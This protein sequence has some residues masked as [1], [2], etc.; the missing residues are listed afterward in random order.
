MPAPIKK[1]VVCDVCD[2]LYRSNTTF[3]FLKF[4]FQ[5]E[6]ILKHLALQIMTSKWSLVYYI[7]IVGSKILEKDMIRSL[8]VRLL[9]GYSYSRILSL[10]GEFFDH[11]LNERKN[12]KIFELLIQEKK[13]NYVILVSSSID[14]VI[15]TIANQHGFSYLS[16]VLEVK[17]GKITGRFRSD[18]THKK[19]EE[20]KELM[21]KSP[22]GRLVVITDN[23]SDFKL[24]EMA[25]ERYV[26]I[27]SEKEKKFWMSLNPHFIVP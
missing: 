11:Y 5:K 27:Q 17:E 2:T 21:E 7:L 26:V 25:D 1:I 4:V 20:V 19:H 10:A 16:S 9:A 6:G 14:P 22:S 13:E 24:V 15:K 18:L 8:S 12:K 23:H 3:D